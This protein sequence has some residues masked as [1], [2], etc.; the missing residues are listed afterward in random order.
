[1]SLIH[2][3]CSRNTREL[4]NMDYRSTYTRRFMT[5]PCHLRTSSSVSVYCENDAGV[6]ML[7]RARQCTC[8]EHSVQNTPQRRGKKETTQLCVTDPNK[9]LTCSRF[10]QSL[11]FNEFSSSNNVRKSRFMEGDDH[12][13]SPGVQCHTHDWTCGLVHCKTSLCVVVPHT[14]CIIP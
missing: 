3:A 6:K 12:V 1:M 14:N 9:E 10:C 2:H 8:Q 13:C 11:P 4:R 7:L 5:I